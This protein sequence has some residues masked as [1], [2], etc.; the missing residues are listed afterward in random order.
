MGGG[1][2]G[3]GWREGGGKGKEG[4]CY[5][6]ESNTEQHSVKALG[7]PQVWKPSPATAPVIKAVYF[8]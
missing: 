4:S 8:C 1:L 7:S 3:D 6:Q 5:Q 2:L